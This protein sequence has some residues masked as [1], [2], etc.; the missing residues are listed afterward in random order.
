M[1]EKP[2]AVKVKW[3]VISSVHREIFSRRK[4]DTDIAVAR[5]VIAVGNLGSCSMRSNRDRKVG[6]LLNA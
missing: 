6:Q 4:P 3:R 2:F 1:V 5:I